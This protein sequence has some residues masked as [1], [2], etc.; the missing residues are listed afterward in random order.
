LVGDLHAHRGIKV[1]LSSGGREATNKS[2][3]I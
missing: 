2:H 1:S 3:K